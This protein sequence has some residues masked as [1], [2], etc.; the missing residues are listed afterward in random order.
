MNGKIP[1]LIFGLIAG[2]MV[3]SAAGQAVPRGGLWRAYLES[4]GG[5]LPFE[6]RITARSSVT[7]GGWLINGEEEIEIPRVSWNGNAFLFDIDY[8][9]SRITATV[10]ANGSRMSG[11]WERRG[12]GGQTT[13][14]LFHAKLG[15]ARRFP[16]IEQTS[17]LPVEP[18]VDGR[19]S[20][21]FSSSDDPAV[22]IFNRQPDD[23]IAGTF[24]T[25]TGD[26]RYLSGN[27]DGDRL[28]LSCF[29][30]AHA[31]L[32]DARLQPDGT[33]KG[34]FWSRDTWHETWT[35]RLN[36]DATLPD[37]F[38]M[39][40]WTGNARLA[41]LAFPDPEGT[42]SSLVDPSFAGKAR[43]IVVF[44]T[45]CPNCH[46][47]T[48]YLVELDRRY[49]D[50]GLSIL[51]LAFEYS[52]DFKRDAKQ[53]RTY[54]E[55]Q[56]ISYPVL[57][58]GMSEKEKAS[59]ALPVLDRLRAYPTTIFLDERGEMRAI[60]TGFNGPATGEEHTRLRAQFEKLIEELL[61]E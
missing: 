29:D 55:R 23:S 49:R 20:V 3:C 1:L 45:W 9:D 24:L 25:A 21:Q 60:H 11:Q 44:G 53:V 7:W 27:L 33:L 6:F 56:R 35:A 4:P 13:R 28:R 22:A 54:I 17:T 19:W 18:T 57:I 43:M 48:K 15:Q 30:G 26:Y 16:R 41:D 36:P 46:D 10:E 50:R 38:Q 14:M 37:S 31:F 8:Y 47:L 5:D 58:A 2:P 34:D 59:A 32:F 61:A 42:P 39:T 12:A 51:G 40:R 52:G